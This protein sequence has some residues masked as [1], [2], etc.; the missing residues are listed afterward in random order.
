M[1]DEPEDPNDMSIPI[2]PERGYSSAC[3]PVTGYRLLPGL[4]KIFDGKEA[5]KHFYSQ[6]LELRF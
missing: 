1:D 4:H 5:S 3:N 2:E 6:K